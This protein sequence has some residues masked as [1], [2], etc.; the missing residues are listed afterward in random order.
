[1]DPRLKTSPS[2]RDCLRVAEDYLRGEGWV[3]DL[4]VSRLRAEATEKV[5]QAIATVQREPAPDPFKEE[6]CALASKHLSEGLT[7]TSAP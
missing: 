1:V 4:A 5:E 3:D 2:G 6:W 7:D